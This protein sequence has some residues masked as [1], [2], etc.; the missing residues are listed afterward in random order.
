M[1]VGL[2]AFPGLQLPLSLVAAGAGWGPD[3]PAVPPPECRSSQRTQIPRVGGASIG[4]A[5]GFPWQPE[6]RNRKFPGYFRGREG[7]EPCLRVVRK[8][9]ADSGEAQR[10]HQ[11][12]A[13]RRRRKRRRPARE[14]PCPWDGEEGWDGRWG[15]EGEEPGWG[16][17]PPPDF[18]PPPHPGWDGPQWGGRG[19]PAE[20]PRG[21]SWDRV[22]EGPRTEGLFGEGPRETWDAPAREG[23]APREQVRGGEPR[24][25]M[26]SGPQSQWGSGPPSEAAQEQR[27]CGRRSRW[28]GRERQARQE[29]PQ[30]VREEPLGK[31]RWK[32]R[33]D[34][35]RRKEGEMQLQQLLLLAPPPARGHLGQDSPERVRRQ[36][37]QLGGSNGHHGG[38][39]ELERETRHEG[40]TGRRRPRREQLQASPVEAGGQ[41][42]GPER[43]EREPHSPARGERGWGNHSRGRKQ[44]GPH[45]V[46]RNWGSPDHQEDLGTFSGQNPPSWK[47]G[48][49]ECGGGRWESPECSRQEHSP[50]ARGRSPNRS[51]AQQT[52]SRHWG[53]PTG[54]KRRW[55]SAGAD[56]GTLEWEGNHEENADG[57]GCSPAQNSSSAQVTSSTVATP[58][59]TSKMWAPR[60]QVVEYWMKCRSALSRKMKDRLLSVCPRPTLPHRMS[61]TPRLN[62]EIASLLNKNKERLLAA[63]IHDMN[64]LQNEVLD[65]LAPAMTIYEMAE[66]ALEKQEGVDPMELREWARRLIRYI[67]SM[68]YRLTMQRRLQV[69]GAINPRLRSVSSKMISQ[70]TDGMLFAEDKVKL[71]REIIM[72][73]PQLTQPAKNLIHKRYNQFSRGALNAAGF[74]H[75]RPLPWRPGSRRQPGNAQPQSTAAQ[76][77]KQG[78]Q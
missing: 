41:W 15:P 29:P 17:G 50:L 77:A 37:Q 72:R 25:L 56:V 30:P 47:Q 22:W 65:M 27:P 38:W 73:F 58:L 59:L 42:R 64:I 78:Q 67:G 11:A 39:A 68:N 21:G 33:W 74:A 3:G 44:E 57:G 66:E 62:P 60:E 9:M 55:S 1:P 45:R 75:L 36:Q 52:P 46:E 6:S 69:L 43:G 28:D 20:P 24:H 7:K 51:D 14:S 32:T 34:S 5:N 61:E 23:R 13:A 8:G 12:D 4:R 19:G 35:P 16:G 40:S 26:P 2:T 48:S 76:W 31:A 10:P 54:F 70:S 53:S 63:A 71:L 18:A 49:V